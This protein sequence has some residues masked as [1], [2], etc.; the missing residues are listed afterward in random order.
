MKTD[1]DG[2]V[3][4][5]NNAQNCTFGLLSD[6]AIYF[7]YWECPSVQQLDI[8]EMLNAIK[9]LPMQSEIITFTKNIWQFDG[10]ENDR[11]KG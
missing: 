11:E 7:S 5:S 3:G 9:L 8:V 10:Y 6:A 1:R 2:D 4:T